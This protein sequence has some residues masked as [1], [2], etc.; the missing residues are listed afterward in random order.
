MAQLI[1][2]S[3]PINL[4]WVV[5]Q[6]K[7][8]YDN[9]IAVVNRIDSSFE[10]LKT[11]YGT[12]IAK[13]IEFK[14][15]KPFDKPREFTKNILGYTQGNRGTE[16]IALDE[17]I[18]AIRSEIYSILPS[19]RKELNLV[20]TLYEGTCSRPRGDSDQDWHEIVQDLIFQNGKL[21]AAVNTSFEGPVSEFYQDSR[22]LKIDRHDLEV[23][24]SRLKI[25][26]NHHDPSMEIYSG[27]KYNDG[28]LL[29]L[30]NGKRGKLVFVK[31]GEIQLSKPL[32]FSAY[33]LGADSKGNVFIGKNTI[34]PDGE[35][36]HVDLYA[37]RLDGSIYMIDEFKFSKSIVSIGVSTDDTIY[38]GLSEK[39]KLNKS[40]IRT[41]KLV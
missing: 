5:T 2:A 14:D 23:N 18:T 3:N 20:T 35:S 26:K 24:V 11:P 41:F 25:Q 10:W 4:D 21:Y 13:L 19:D 32:H 30:S 6:I 29:G 12:S 15:G 17:N 28:I 1:P 22:L 37:V 40:E 31:D 9:M 38:V 34:S 33:A 36:A 27:I 8:F 16:Y 39:P 7:P